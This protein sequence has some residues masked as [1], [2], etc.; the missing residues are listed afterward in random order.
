MLRHLRAFA[1]G[2]TYPVR[3]ARRRPL[4]ALALA[5]LAVAAV[6]L[7]GVGYARHQW[8]A[9]QAALAAGRPAEARSRLAVCLWVWP[10][11]LRTHLLAAR[12]ARLCGDRQSAEDH[13]NRCLRLHGGATEEVQLE[14]LLLRVQS[15]DLEEVAP[16]LIDCVEKGHPESPLILETLAQAYL[17]LLRYKAAYACLSRWIEIRPDEPKAY[18]WRGWALERLNQPKSAAENYA[19]ALELEPDLLVVR[20]RVAEMLLD[21][22]RAPE[23]IPHLER[24]YRQAP[25]N[26]EVQARLGMCRFYENR[27]AEARRLM[28]AA[29]V[30][31]PKDAALLIHLAKLDL[32]E[33]RA[34][35]AEQRLRQV[36]A[37]DRSDSEAWYTLSS[38]LQFQGRSS[39]SAVAMKEYQRSK[40][41]V[42]RANKLLQEVADSPKAT[43]ADYA[44]IGELLLRIGGRDRLGVYWLGQALERDPDCRPAHAAL[45]AYYEKKGEAEKAA[46]HRRA[47]PSN[48]KVTR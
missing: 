7:G 9:A 41:E 36:L 22:K 32:Q 3:A 13:L 44:E 5:A 34:A 14:F 19:R 27:P 33:G 4:L 18:Q 42:D 37:A 48:D 28:E 17:H 8:R 47:L 20:L 30:H 23:A 6:G 46:A 39:E 29:A 35:E 16:T 43:A 21:D 2:F 38:V 45:A 1:R 40:D 31:M 15:G 10:W 26:P 12:A 11:D 25:D 24:L